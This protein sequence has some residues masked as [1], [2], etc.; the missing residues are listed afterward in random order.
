M[1]GVV[2]AMQVVVEGRDKADGE[3]AM[4]K[5]REISTRQGKEIENSLP[6]LVR[7]DPFQPTNRLLGPEGQRWVPIHAMAPHSRVL[8]LLRAV[9]QYFNEHREVV[10]KNG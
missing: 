10:E 3:S 9:D 6:K 2:L 7:A 5:V 4:K 1:E 8:P